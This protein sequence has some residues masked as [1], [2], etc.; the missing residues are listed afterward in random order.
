MAKKDSKRIA[1][2]NLSTKNSVGDERKRKRLTHQNIEILEEFLRLAPKKL[3]KFYK[4]F[5]TSKMH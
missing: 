1:F 4:V 3:S 5:R 2:D